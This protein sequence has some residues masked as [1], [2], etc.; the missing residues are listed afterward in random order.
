MSLSTAERR[1]RMMVDLP[2]NKQGDP[3]DTMVAV[4]AI[5]TQAGGAKKK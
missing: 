1:T 4:V 3:T 5:W 2:G